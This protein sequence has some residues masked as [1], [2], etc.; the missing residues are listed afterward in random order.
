MISPKEQNL[1]EK[2]KKKRKQFKKRFTKT[3]SLGLFKDKK[4]GFIINRNKNELLL[5][6]AAMNNA[7]NTT[8][9]NEKVKKLECELE[10][11][12]QLLIKVV[13]RN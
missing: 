5:T 11:L 6:K 8:F 1:I 7:K 2:I 12:K 9:N 10:E 4:T 3:N 13:E